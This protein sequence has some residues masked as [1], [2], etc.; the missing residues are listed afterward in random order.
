MT[1]SGDVIRVTAKTRISTEMAVK[2]CSTVTSPEFPHRYFLGVNHEPAGASGI[3]VCVGSKRGCHLL[4]GILYR[5]VG[6]DNQAFR[7]LWALSSLSAWKAW[8]SRPT[9]SPSTSKTVACCPR[10][11]A[12]AGCLAVRWK[13][14]PFLPPPACSVPQTIPRGMCLAGWEDGS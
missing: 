3:G 9:A 11:G 1:R 6:L 7:V 5:W 14:K 4:L 2:H 8:E 13:D 10:V 12:E